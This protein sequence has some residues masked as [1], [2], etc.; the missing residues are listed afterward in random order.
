[1]PRALWTGASGM[2]A[3]QTNVDIISNNIANVNTTA[4]KAQRGDFQDLFYDTTTAP[5]VRAGDTGRNPTGSQIGNGVRLSSTPR[6]FTPGSIQSTGQAT[7]MAI[8]GDGFFAVTMPDGTT[9]YTRAGDFAP[10]ADGHLVTP[11]GYLLNP[12][13][14]IPATASQHQRLDHRRGHRP[15][16]RQHPAADHRHAPAHQVPQSARPARPRAEPLHRIAAS[17]QPQVG[18]PGANGLGTILGGNLEQ[19]NV[20]VVTELVNLIVAQR[21]YDMNSK[22]IQT[23][24][25]MLETANQLVT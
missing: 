21:A 8:V 9:A 15:A 16:A 20:Q 24:N 5:G 22:S 7:N 18:T 23:S 17:G 10:D 13:I 2:A 6:L 3:Q 25:Q 4:F 1:M 12:A 11:D 14:T 19:S